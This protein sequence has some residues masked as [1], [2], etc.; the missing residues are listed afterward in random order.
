MMKLAEALRQAKFVDIFDLL[1]SKLDKLK[2]WELAEELSDIRNT[3]TMMLRFMVKGVNDP[4]SPRLIN[5]LLR[6]S[7]VVADRA[8]RLL[9]IRQ[10]A[11]DRYTLALHDVHM[12]M[13]NLLMSLE[14]YWSGMAGLQSGEESVRRSKREH[15]ETELVEMHEKAVS[16]MFASVWTS[17]IW[18]K[19]DH[20]IAD[21]IMQSE[22]V[23]GFDKAVLVSAVTLA[24]LE[25]F[26]ERKVMFLFDSYLSDDTE[27]C[28]RA[29]V[30]ILLVLR[31]FDERISCYPEISSRL[32][33]YAENESFVKNLYTLMM[34]LQFSKMTDKVSAKMRTD[35]IPTIMKSKNFKKRGLGLAEVDAELTKNDE[36]PEWYD[37]KNDDKASEK[38]REM[39]DLQLEGADVYMG[40]FA[41]MKSYPF[42]SKLS[43]WFYPFTFDV[44]EMLEAKKLLEGKSALVVK[45]MLGASP[46]CN[47]DKYSFCLMMNTIGSAA[48]QMLAQQM[49]NEAGEHMDSLVEDAM[50]RKLKPVDVSRFYIYDLYRF[51]KAYP[52]KNEFDDM[53]SN[54]QPAFSP[55]HTSSL[56]FMLTQR[57]ELL[58]LGEFLMRKSFYSDAISIFLSLNPEEVEHDAHLWQKI[59]F[60]Q[61]KMSDNMAALRSFIK[62]D[63]LQPDSR[64]TKRHL[65]TVA[66]DTRN[67]D[68]AERYYDQL[69]ALDDTSLKSLHMKARCMMATKR[70]SDAIPVLYKLDYLSEKTAESQ[71]MLA[72]ALLLSG[73]TEKAEETLRTFLSELS[74]D[75]EHLN[76]LLAHICLVGGKCAEAYAA[77]RQLCSDHESFSRKYWADAHLICDALQLDTQ[78]FNLMHD[79]VCC[80]ALDE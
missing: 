75:H 53:F 43:H 66:F 17:D 79:A 5:S 10:H 14:A 61:Q 40:T 64:W 28:Q 13:D 27:V 37:V 44:P 11:S 62:A 48:E 16:D 36:N 34:Q 24:L 59:G 77:Y 9:R 3:Y 1:G 60:C 19:S 38:I 74:D 80:G 6:R 63:S 57:D 31:K 51:F 29:L 23:G 35:I 73:N 50:K 49:E 69:L 46:F 15:A 22:S 30:G 67:Y 7:Y 70:Y 56:S 12:P 26:D 76:M 72:R 20:D 52:Y 8:E 2:D 47:S 55:I 21:K 78:V 58:A 45:T 32:A 18:K 65:A 54:K 4:E 33:L 41:Y 42:F 39:A 68:I 25:M 71:Y